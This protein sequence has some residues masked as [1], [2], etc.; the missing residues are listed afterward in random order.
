MSELQFFARR[1]GR[2]IMELVRRNIRPIDILTPQ[3]FRNA[4]IVHS[5]IGGSTNGLIHLPAIAKELGMELD[6]ELFNEINPK[7]PHIGN[8]NPSGKHLTE[9]FWFAGGIP[10]VQRMLADYLDLDVMTVTGKTLGE[11]LEELEKNSFFEIGAGL[12][13]QLWSAGGGCHHSFGDDGR[14][15]KYRGAEGQSGSGRS[16]CQIFCL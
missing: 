5:A 8:I 16:R 7:I 4:I 14:N 12:S 3:A 2:T 13:A 6:P 9:S 11:N 1:A 15:G 10:R